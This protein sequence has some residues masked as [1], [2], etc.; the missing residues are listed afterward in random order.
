MFMML[1]NVDIEQ[2]MLWRRKIVNGYE[3]GHKTVIK[4]YE[5]GQIHGKHK[6]S[7]TVR[8]FHRTPNQMMRRLYLIIK[9]TH[10]ISHSNA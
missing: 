8:Y 3:G 10:F 7:K 9:F 4:N 1:N 6:K 2:D 5:M